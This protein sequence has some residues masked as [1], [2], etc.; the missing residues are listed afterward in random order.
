VVNNN[1]PVTPEMYRK[2]KAES[3]LLK[4]KEVKLNPLVAGA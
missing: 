1:F 2:R 3:A 4:E